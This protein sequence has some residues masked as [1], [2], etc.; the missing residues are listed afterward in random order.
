[1]SK[2]F[3]IYIGPDLISGENFREKQRE[4]K[5]DIEKDGAKY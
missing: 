2:I 4:R 1:M 5:E 3:Q